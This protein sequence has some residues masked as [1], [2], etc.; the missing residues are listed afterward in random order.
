MVLGKADR[1]ELIRRGERAQVILNDPLVQEAFE[2]IESEVLRVWKGTAA[3]DIPSRERAW[4]AL[5]LIGSVRRAFEGIVTSGQYAEHEVQEF[6]RPV[7]ALRQP[8]S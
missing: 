8:P 4:L 3:S 2:I 5:Q 7:D 1:G 6:L